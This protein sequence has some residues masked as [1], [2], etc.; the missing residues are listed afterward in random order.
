MNKDRELGNQGIVCWE[1]LTNVPGEL[2][3]CE[4]RLASVSQDGSAEGT[5][6][7]LFYGQVGFSGRGQHYSSLQEAP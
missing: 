4:S 3:Q 7:E 6:A 5:E 2:S 1:A